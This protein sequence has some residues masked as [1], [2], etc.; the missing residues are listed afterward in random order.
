MAEKKEASVEK[1]ETYE[2]RVTVLLPRARPGEEETLFV[3]VNGK[4]YRIRKGVSVSVPR[5]VAEVL[6]QSEL[7]KEKAYQY[8]STL[9]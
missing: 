4:G 2:D 9:G 8:Q 1:K 7:A 6:E 3:G 5:A